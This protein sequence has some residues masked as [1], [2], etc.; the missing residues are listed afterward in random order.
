M[1]NVMEKFDSELAKLSHVELVARF[2]AEVGK[3][4]WVNARAY[5]L[6]ALRNQFANRSIDYALI[7]NETGGLNLGNKVQL[8]GGKLIY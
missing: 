1:K 7:Q 3:R 6:E 5:F 4:G 2:N 8:S